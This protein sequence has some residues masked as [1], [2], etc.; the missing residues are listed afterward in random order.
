MAGRAVDALKVPDSLAGIREVVCQE[1]S[2]ILPVKDAR[3]ALRMPQAN[4]AAPQLCQMRI[5]RTT[6]DST[7]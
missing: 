1:A 6:F 4:Q 5:R 3:E 2:A 7:I